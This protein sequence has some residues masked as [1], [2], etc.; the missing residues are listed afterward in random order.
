MPQADD[1]ALA[2]AF[3]AVARQL[4]RHSREALAPW[5][6]SPSQ[7]RALQVLARHGTMRLRNLADHLHIAPRS[8][9]EVVD[10]L[11]ERGLV[12]RSPDPEDRRATLVGLTGEGGRVLGA[13]HGAREAAAEALFGRLSR[14]DRT[15]LARILRQLAE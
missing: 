14:S 4:R 6:I 12:A 3:W 9:T 13:L 11:Q 8:A 2:D 1:S 15:D 7:V 5:G 10:G